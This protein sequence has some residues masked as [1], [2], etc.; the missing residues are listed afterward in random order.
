MRSL[1]VW[2][3][4]AGNISYLMV[5]GDKLHYDDIWEEENASQLERKRIASQNRRQLLETLNAEEMVRIMFKDYLHKLSDYKLNKLK[6][7]YIDDKES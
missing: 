6:R 4:K 5:G 7:D 3:N 2:G 1:G